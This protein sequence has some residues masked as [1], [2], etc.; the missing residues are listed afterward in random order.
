MIQIINEERFMG[1]DC[2]L[3]DKPICNVCG[4]EMSE[5]DLP[6]DFEPLDDIVCKECEEEFCK[7][8]IKGVYN[9]K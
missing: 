8:I 3:I 1:D 6:E 4:V 9:D 5:D 2:P 7:T